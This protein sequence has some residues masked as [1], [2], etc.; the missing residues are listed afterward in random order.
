MVFA[1]NNKKAIIASGEQVP[2]P[3]NVQSSFTG[4][5]NNNS[6]G[7]VSNATVEYKD[8]VLK[9]EVNPLINSDKEVTLDILQEVNDLGTSSL[10]GG[11][12]VPS[13]TSRRVKTTVSVANEATVVLGGLVTERRTKS[14]S[15]L[16]ILG[17]LPVFGPLFSVTT[18]KKQRSEL[19]VLIRPTVTMSPVEAVKAGERAEERMTIPPDL[20]ATLDPKGSK[21]NVEEKRTELLR[22]PKPVLRSAK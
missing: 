2:V 10:I 13:I 6:N 14:K 12:E 9:L 3:G 16:P 18:D 5:V 8:V 19:L 1:S 7:L 15:G 22:K 4:L 21:V 11:N 17:R 20:D